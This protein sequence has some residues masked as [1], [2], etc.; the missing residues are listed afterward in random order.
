[1]GSAVLT[2]SLRAGC[3]CLPCLPAAAKEITCFSLLQSCSF[4]IPLAPLQGLQ[5]ANALPCIVKG[6]VKA[7]LEAWEAAAGA[8]EAAAMSV[9]DL[10]AEKHTPGEASLAEENLQGQQRV[11]EP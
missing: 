2:R 10:Q 4:L 6:R 1:M 7:L 5:Q 3:C 11:P 9:S 8:G